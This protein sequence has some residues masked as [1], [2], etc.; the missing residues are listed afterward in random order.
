MIY[1]IAYID[2]IIFYIYVFMLIHM[3][4]VFRLYGSLNSYICCFYIYMLIILI[5]MYLLMI[6][7]ILLL[8]NRIY[9][10]II[11]CFEWNEEE[12]LALF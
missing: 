9:S 5:N 2:L 11:L 3:S 7:N 1:R 6:Y 8:I 10:V 4:Y 12:I